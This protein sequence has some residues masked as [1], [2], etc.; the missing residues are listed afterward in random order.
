VQIG[1]SL[2]SLNSVKG[3][4]GGTGTSVG[5]GGYA[6]GGGAE[7]DGPGSKLLND[8]VQGNTLTPG[9]SST[10]SGSSYGGGID[11]DSTG[12]TLVNDTVAGNVA[13]FSGG[14]SVA[15]GGGIDNHLGADSLLD[16]YNTL[17]ATN[18][19]TTGP[20]FSGTAAVAQSNL[21][22]NGTGTTS[23]AGPNDNNQVGAGGKAIDPLLGPLQL[24]GGN[25]DTMSLGVGSLAR[26]AG[27]VNAV[28]LFNLTTDQRGTGFARVVN[29]KVDIGAFETAA[30]STA[31][32]V[33][34]SPNP[35]NL[36]ANVTFTATVSPQNG[37]DVTPTGTV[38]FM[39]GATVLGSANLPT[40]SNQVTFSTSS[41]TLGPHT[42]T[43]VYAGDTNFSGST[44]GNFTETVNP[45]TQ[46]IPLSTDFNLT[47]ITT[48]GTPFGG[49]LDAQGNAISESLIGTTVAWDGLTFPIAAPDVPDVVQGGGAIT[50]I[51]VPTG[52]YSSIAILATGTNGNQAAQ[53][54]IINYS[55]GTTS[56][57]IQSISDWHMP[58][59]YAGESIALTTGYRNTSPGGRDNAGPFDVFGY[60]LPVDQ[61][62]TVT[63]ITIPTDSHVK[64]FSMVAV[65]TVAAPT[66]LTAT[67][68]STSS[69][70]LA[71]TAAPGTITGY[72]V[73]RGTGPGGEAATPIA[74]L[75]ASAISYTDST[76]LAAG[77]TYYYTV[78]AI[79][80]PAIS[81]P[82]TEAKATTTPNGP[83]TQ[84]DLTPDFNLLG[85]SA[86][87][88]QFS[89]GGLDGAGNAFS[90][91]LLGT[92]Q[93]VAGVNFTIAHGGTNNVVQALGQTISLPTAA[94]STLTFL[95]TGVNG[96]QPN[97]VFTVHY[98]TGV[99]LP[100][101][102]SISDW[103]GT[104]AGSTIQSFTGQSVA[105]STAYRDT[106][107]GG[108][109]N[110]GPFDVY[111]YSFSI[112]PPP[113]AVLAS[114]SLPNNKDIDIL[115][116]DVM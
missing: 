93:T 54:F 114:I 46:V 36:G 99:N 68:A 48:D 90:S 49:G 6:Y 108:R 98:S 26:G 62:K 89:G 18:T 10:D 63:S 115:A 43:A 58:Q 110:N 2:L 17:V 88:I 37:V 25:T 12:L 109:D 27:S 45:G 31:T 51:T 67:P 9:A 22:G 41:L 20:D 57:D 52:A 24:N 85:I 96:N 95:A 73:Y 61:T 60:S 80:Y 28:N 38:T 75:P 35:V 44:S 83:T 11:D 40:G 102:E 101:P 104:T 14:T 86:D 64:I 30:A 103:N 33:V 34:G 5:H 8:T 69:I 56:T 42:I 7:I 77:N 112:T 76:G 1:D 81:L 55:N 74:T 4:N 91:N 70:A 72:D 16:V 29:G 79:N 78:R 116:I 15:E 100:H 113:N 65:T 13:N 111:V 71:W 47:G 32:A 105:V 94:F 92:S 84:V 66:N 97:Q 106:S 82:S 39:D 107:G 59:N 3:G 87:G 19:A 23:F 21:I 50:T 53:T